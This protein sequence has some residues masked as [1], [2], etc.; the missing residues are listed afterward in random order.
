[1]GNGDKVAVALNDN[2]SLGR[3][4]V[5]DDI[6]DALLDNPVN[7]HFGLFIKQS[8]DIVNMAGEYGSAVFGHAMNQGTES[9]GPTEAGELIRR[10]TMR[11]LPDLFD[12]LRSRRGDFVQLLP[13][14]GV[15]R[16]RLHRA[17][18]LVHN[19]QEILAKAVM[20]IDRNSAPFSLLAFED[21]PGEL[22]PGGV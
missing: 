1:D 6:V 3:I 17:L 11:D 13:Q 20:E 19:D 5:F 9:L 8:V 14:G 12:G 4:G 21:L 18:G 15:I 16:R 2:S 22:E 10:Q 7:M